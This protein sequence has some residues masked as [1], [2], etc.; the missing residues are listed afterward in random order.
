MKKEFLLNFIE[1]YYLNGNVESVIWESKD[2]NFSVRF[3][4]TD[5]S[6]IGG[7]IMKGSDNIPN[8]KF[9]IYTTGDLLNSINFMISENID[10]DL[11]KIG[12]TGEYTNLF[13]TDPDNK[14]KRIDYPLTETS[15]I[16]PPGSLKQEP[17]YNIEII[18]DS[19]FVDD[20]LRGT[21]SI[22][23]SNV[24]IKSLDNEKCLFVFGYNEAVNSLNISFDAKI[25]KFNKDLN[26]IAFPV[27]YLKSILTNNKNMDSGVMYVSEMGLVKIVFVSKIYHATYFMVKSEQH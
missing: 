13:I 20:F 7:L 21:N 2:S 16:S 23:A 14:Q 8:G 12:S 22:E 26:Y 4:T 3:N 1:K 27:D 25:K 17:D 9:G 11:V 24:S 19:S 15:I 6:M 18:I 10:L 5:K